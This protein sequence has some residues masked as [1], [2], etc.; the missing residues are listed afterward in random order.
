M[1]TP[2]YWWQQSIYF[3]FGSQAHLQGQG[4]NVEDYLYW[5]TEIVA[6]K[7]FALLPA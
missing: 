2:S 3:T 1:Q 6:N 5:L 7:Y 4:Y